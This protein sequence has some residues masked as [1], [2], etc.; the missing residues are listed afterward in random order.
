MT[1]YTV[2]IAS[3]LLIGEASALAQR[4]V[5]IR[6]RA[7]DRIVVKDGPWLYG[8]IVGRDANGAVT[9]AVRREWL[10]DD[11]PKFYADEL[12]LKCPTRYDEAVPDQSD[13]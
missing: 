12:L 4:M 13:A 9:I 8:A 11:S 10:K 2:L 1:R 7:V 6:Q 3:V 5:P